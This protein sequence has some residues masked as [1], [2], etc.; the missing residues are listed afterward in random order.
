MARLIQTI[1]QFDADAILTDP[2]WPLSRP[3]RRDP[4]PPPS[5]PERAVASLPRSPHS[6]GRQADS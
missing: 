4:D 6:R 1:G 3:Y 2:H 5:Y